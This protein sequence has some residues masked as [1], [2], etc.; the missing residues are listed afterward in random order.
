MRLLRASQWLT[1]QTYRHCEWNAMAWSNLFIVS[2]K[3]TLELVSWDCFVAYSS[4][5][6]AHQTYRHCEWNAMEWSNLFMVSC[7]YTLE[8]VSWDCL[9][10]RNDGPFHTMTPFALGIAV[11]I[12]LIFNWNISTGHHVKKAKDCNGKP[13]PLG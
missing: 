8:L 11:K 10:P 9:V 7:K 13:D 5:W 4:Q 1:N 6:R 2:C 12:L 3:Y